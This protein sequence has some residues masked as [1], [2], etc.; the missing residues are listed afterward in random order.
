MFIAIY[1][2]LGTTFIHT[3]NTTIFTYVYV[4][5]ATFH[6]GRLEGEKLCVGVHMFKMLNRLS[7]MFMK[8]AMKIVDHVIELLVC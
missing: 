3:Q 5:M 4:S 2:F 8:G 6:S 1:F 7:I